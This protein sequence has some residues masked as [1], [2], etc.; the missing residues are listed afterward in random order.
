MRPEVLALFAAACWALGSL[1]SAKA[2]SHMGAFSFARWRLFFALSLLWA[3]SL[4]TGQWRGLSWDAVW[5]LVASG[6]V[7]IFVGDTAMFACMNR[8][9]PRRTGVLFATHAFFS[10]ALA[11][12]FFGETLWGWALLGSLLLIG[13][14]MVAV[15]WGRHS[16]ETHDWEQTRGHLRIGIALGLIA[17]L[18]QALAT[19]MLKPLM[20]T[21][22]DAITASAVR[23]SASFVVHALLWAMGL[24]L[25][26]HKQPLNAK[27]LWNT[28]WSAAVAMALGMTLILAALR[29]GQA[30]L[31]GVFSSVTP[32]LLLPLLWL[33]Y[34]RRP[35]L[36][37]WLGAIMAVVG[38]AMILRLH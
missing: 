19:L 23:T 30:N 13:G 28:F 18:G 37:A 5:L 12:V 20:A 36:G 32:V 15:A 9:G 7:G 27:V 1:F 25:A 17:A 14:V 2:A 26:Q 21:G 29:E 34:R 22:L 33:V 11:W 24:K 31:V 10:V 16:D 8:L 38:T 3:L 4:T 35:A 6:L